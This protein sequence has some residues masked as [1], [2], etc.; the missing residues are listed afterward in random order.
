MDN[1]YSIRES[2]R[3]LKEV[4]NHF[5]KI[6]DQIF[7]AY[8]QKPLTAET[9]APKIIRSNSNHFTISYAYL[10]NILKGST[11]LNFDGTEKGWL[12][13]FFFNI[14]ED[15]F[16]LIK[17]RFNGIEMFKETGL[18]VISSCIK[19]NAKNDQLKLVSIRAFLDE[20]EWSGLYQSW[21]NQRII[22]EMFRE[23]KVQVP[24]FEE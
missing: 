23:D 21:T 2:A 7:A 4:G 6:W 12:I 16:E 15:D 5:I 8:W 13:E 22:K 1:F 19:T 10:N 9:I 14:H 17:E 3:S 18:D 20:T 24:D 11:V